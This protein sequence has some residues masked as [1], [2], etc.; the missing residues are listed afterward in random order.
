MIFLI[1]LG[2]FALGVL[3]GECWAESRRETIPYNY[4]NSVDSDRVQKLLIDSIKH[5]RSVRRC[6]VETFVKGGK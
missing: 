5:D 6:S 4:D 1:C 3:V 2:V